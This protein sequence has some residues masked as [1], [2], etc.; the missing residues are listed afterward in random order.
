MHAVLIRHLCFGV[1]EIPLLKRLP[2]GL[3]AHDNGVDD[4]VGVEGELILTEDAEL[5]GADDVAFLGVELAGAYKT[6]V[7]STSASWGALPGWS[8]YSTPVNSWA[9]SLGVVYTPSF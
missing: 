9:F 3:V 8:P 6:T 5:A 4:A 1:D 2:E 7:W